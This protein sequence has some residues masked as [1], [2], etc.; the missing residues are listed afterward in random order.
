MTAPDVRS[1]IFDLDGTLYV[2]PQFAADIRDAAAEFLSK[3]SGITLA[4]SLQRI[5]ETRSQ[6]KETTGAEP[7][8]S[9][10]CLSLGGTLQGLHAYFADRLQPERFLTRDHRV[11]ALLERLA[12]KYHLLLYTNNNR[13]LSDR[14]I[15]HLGID[16][17]FSATYTIDSFWQAKPDRDALTGI[18]RD[19]GLPPDKLLFIGDRYDIDLRLPEELGCR[20]WLSR[21]ID[22]L[23]QLEEMLAG[24]HGAEKDSCRGDACLP[25]SQP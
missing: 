23:L 8:L 14:I 2:S 10:I 16:G 12:A 1:I 11:I 24:C 13:T 18:I 5:R 19:T 15:R 4:E 7:A 25:A 22:R 6:I 9:A 17:F 20:I 21:S 3:L